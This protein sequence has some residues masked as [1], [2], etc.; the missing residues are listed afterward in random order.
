M[1]IEELFGT[2]NGVIHP[3]RALCCYYAKTGSVMVGFEA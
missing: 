1:R 2:F 3:E